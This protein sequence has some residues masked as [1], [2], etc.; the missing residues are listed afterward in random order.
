M[1]VQMVTRKTERAT[2]YYVEEN[3]KRVCQCRT[4]AAAKRVM[5]ALHALSHKEA[6]FNL[7]DALKRD[8]TAREAARNQMA[9]QEPRASGIVVATRLP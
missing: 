4:R 8:A 1:S 6:Q 7:E 3:G 5:V 2:Y 9:N